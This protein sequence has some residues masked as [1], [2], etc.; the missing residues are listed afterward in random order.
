VQDDTPPPRGGGYRSSADT[1]RFD[2]QTA[3]LWNGPPLRAAFVAQVLG[4]LL[5]GGQDSRQSRAAYS[6]TR[7]R[8][9]RVLD[10]TA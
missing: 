2:T 7:A 4:E 3:P 6:D 1:S 9:G 8:L 10:R 5:P